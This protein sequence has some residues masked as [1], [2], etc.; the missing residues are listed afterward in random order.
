M[1]GLDERFLE[2]TRRRVETLKQ[3][4]AGLKAG[5]RDPHAQKPNLQGGLREISLLYE[6]AREVGAIPIVQFLH[7][8]E[9]L[10]LEVV[11]KRMTLVP[12]RGEGGAAR[13]GSLV[14]MAPQ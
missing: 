7:R 1:E 9:T 10:L 4:V 11:Y 14:P 8:L 3:A 6:M 12:Q 2:E 13:V 5:T